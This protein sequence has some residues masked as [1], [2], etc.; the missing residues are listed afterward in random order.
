MERGRWFPRQWSV[1]CWVVACSNRS[2]SS[3]YQHFEIP[4]NL[5]LNLL[6]GF[7]QLKSAVLFC[8]SRGTFTL[9]S[10]ICTNCGNALLSNITCSCFSATNFPLSVDTYAREAATGGWALCSMTLRRGELRGICS[11]WTVGKGIADSDVTAD[12]FLKEISKLVCWCDHCRGDLH[13]HSS[14]V[15]C[16]NKIESKISFTNLKFVFSKSKS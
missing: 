15:N 13:H 1:P 12:R 7:A 4:V 6:I 3:T 5:S 2:V 16:W 14:I 9:S 10:G 11:K 8:W